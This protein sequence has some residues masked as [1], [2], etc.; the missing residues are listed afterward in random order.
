TVTGDALAWLPEASFAVAVSVS[1]PPLGGRSANVTLKLSDRDVNGG[2]IVRVS[3]NVAVP[4]AASDISATPPASSACTVTVS[5][6]R[7]STDA[8]D[9]GLAIEICGATVSIPRLLTLVCPATTD[10]R[11]VA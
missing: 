7:G 11:A 9:V 10:A 2:A 3:A 1:V 4:L 8:F 6:L 5:A